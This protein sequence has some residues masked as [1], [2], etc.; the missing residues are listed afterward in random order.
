[1]FSSQKDKI[2]T[3]CLVDLQIIHLIKSLA[4][5]FSHVQSLELDQPYGH[6]CVIGQ[7]HIKQIF[8]KSCRKTRVAT[9]VTT[10]SFKV[11]NSYSAFNISECNVCLFLLP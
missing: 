3:T 1:M 4:K 9:C 6:Q 11:N 7:Q 8:Y 5:I 2:Y 10:I